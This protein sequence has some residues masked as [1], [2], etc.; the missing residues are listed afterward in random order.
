MKI[1]P[2]SSADFILKYC[3]FLFL[4]AS[5][6]GCSNEQEQQERD[7]PNIIYIL[8]DDLGY[9]ELGAYGQEKI[10]TPNI[11]NLASSGMMFTQHYAGSPVCAPSRYMLMTGK[12]PGNATIRG[13]D[14]WNER[15]DV[16]SFDAMLEN[17]ELEGQRPIP[18][19][20]ITIA[21]M[22]KEAG[23][24][25]GAIGKWGLGGPNTDGHPNRQGFD[26]F[27]GYLCQRQAHTYYP[28]HLWKNDERVFLRNEQV[29]PHQ[30]LPEDADPYDLQSYAPF[31]NQPDY[32]AG[33]MH[34][35]ALH[36]IEEHRDVPFFLYLPTP[37]PHVS[38]QAP[39][40][41]VDYYHDKFGDEEP[42]PGGNYT[43][44][45]Y[46]NATYAAMIS[47]LDEQVGD[48]VQKLRELD[49]YENTIIMITSD[50][51]PTFTGG[52]DPAFFGSAAPFKGEYGWGKGFLHEGGIRVPMIAAWEG[53]IPAGTVSNH[54][55]AFWDVMPTFAEISGATKPE[56]IDGISFMN[57]LRG[58]QETQKEHD[59]LYW[60]FPQY[61]G[62]QAVRMGNWKGIRKKLISDNNLEIELYDLDSDPREQNNIAGQ[63][64]DIVEEIRVI[65]ET[66]HTPSKNE[67]FKIPALGD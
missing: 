46:P 30:R 5:A 48:L 63:H 59:F 53:V 60:E 57:T 18:P 61:G 17:P 6:I 3:V 47:Y 13:N 10:E 14:E 56:N 41:W 58:N 65:M 64:P 19:E 38:L 45:R 62:Q 37:I 35:Q 28:T 20:T 27:Y 55:S 26:F 33:L 15:G 43:P 50:N 21:K 67:L 1:F 52:V 2:F 29:H 24:A 8:A 44:V 25:T 49:L 11:D 36:F 22:L 42:Y 4:L 34:A 23:Y 40:R 66:A 31:Y 39:Q 12:H 32:A 9:G 7:L 51:G 54:V 16:W